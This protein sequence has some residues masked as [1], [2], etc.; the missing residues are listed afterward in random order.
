MVVRKIDIMGYEQERYSSRI[1]T[2]V[3][4]SS[5]GLREVQAGSGLKQTGRETRNQKKVKIQYV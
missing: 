1:W 5:T 4:Q 2:L 3:E